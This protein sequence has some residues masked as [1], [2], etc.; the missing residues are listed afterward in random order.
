[1]QCG[2]AGVLEANGR[3]KPRTALYLNDPPPPP[4]ASQDDVREVCSLLRSTLDEASRRARLVCICI[5]ICVYVHEC[6]CINI[7]AYIYIYIRA[8]PLS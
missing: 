4:N 6:V 2:G 8:S 3:E 1:M 7:C 5:C